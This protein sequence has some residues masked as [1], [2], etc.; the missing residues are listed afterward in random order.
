MPL[1]NLI[2]RVGNIIVKKLIAFLSSMNAPNKTTATTAAAADR[3]K[4]YEVERAKVAGVDDIDFMKSN[5]MHELLTLLGLQEF[6]P[7]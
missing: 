6:P 5:G 7:G 2:R 3:S 1:F 4:Q